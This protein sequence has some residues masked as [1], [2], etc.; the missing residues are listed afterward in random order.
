MRVVVTGI[1]AVSPLGNTF[2]D[3]WRALKAGKSGIGPITRFDTS[4]IPWK[5][6]GELKDFNAADYLPQKDIRRLDP[7]I[8]YA[9]A[10]ARMAVEDAG[11]ENKD[12]SSAGIVIGSGRGGISSLEKGLRTRP[13]AYLMAGTTVSMAASYTAQ[14]LGIKGH[15]LG[16]STACSSGAHAVG[17]AFRLIRSGRAGALLAGGAEAPICRLCIRGYGAAGALSKKGITRP[18]DR[19]RDGFVLAE[20]A[21]VLVLEEYD[22]AR[23]RGARIY[24]EILG[25]GN[26]A[27]AFHQ[28]I[29]DRDGQ[30]RAI[31][32]AMKEAGVTPANVDYL[33]A[34]ATST[35]VGDKTEAEAIRLVFGNSNVPVSAVKSMT[36]HML[37][38]S[39]AFEAASTLMSLK[40]GI[41]PPTINLKDPEGCLNYLRK[42]RLR[43]TGKADI[44]IAV[45]S[46]FGFGGVNAVL[47]FGALAG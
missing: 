29:P 9:Y 21:S 41:L 28:T 35:P 1:G 47:V 18:F 19:M 27:D 2:K 5:T 6:A 10:A 32:A 44:S 20:G 33:S 11:L 45:S 42:G 38:A 24:G 34:H 39:G 37:G 46:S 13:S 14:R 4:D 3:S 17:E 16:I 8:H 31:K 7:F 40:E 25:Y 22:S 43:K 12:L 23:K 30:A 15:S 26:T 36:G